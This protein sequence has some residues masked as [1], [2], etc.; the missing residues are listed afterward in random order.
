MTGLVLI[1]CRAAS[2]FVA[3]T[4]EPSPTVAPPNEPAHTQIATPS[5]ALPATKTFQSPALGLSLEYPEAWYIQEGAPGEANGVL[6]TSYDPASPPHKLEWDSQTVSIGIQLIAF[7]A[8][9]P[10]LDAWVESARQAAVSTQLEVFKEERILIAQD[11]PAARLTL[12]S[13]SGGIIDQVLILIDGNHYEFIIQGNFDLAKLV[14]DTLHTMTL[15]KPPDSD[16]PVSGI[17]GRAEAEI[18]EIILTIEG[19]AM[20]RCV[21]VTSE[22]RLKFTNNKDRMAQL[23][24]GQYSLSLPPGGEILIDHPVGEYLAPGVHLIEGAEIILLGDASSQSTESSPPTY[25]QYH[26][27]VAGYSLIYPNT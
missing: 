19:P 13:G 2:R 5:E 1:S 23:N 24:L 18:V 4:P 8:A 6:I 25:N 20:P 17:C 15:L 21:Q 16:S 22:Q 3:A 11:I 9:P 10:S 12:V 26:N 27:P 7:E 14:L